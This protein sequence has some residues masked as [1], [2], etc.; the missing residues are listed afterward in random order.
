MSYYLITA[1]VLAGFSVIFIIQNVAAVDV[2]FLFWT[3]SLSSALLIF[4]TLAIGFL[5]G[6]F[7]HSYYAY[8]RSKPTAPRHQP[9][10]GN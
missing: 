5:L 4:F 10:A 1:F 6:W 2:N 8:L 7:L 3:L 9:P